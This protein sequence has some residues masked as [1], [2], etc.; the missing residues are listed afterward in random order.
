MMDIPNMKT[1]VKPV[2]VILWGMDDLLNWSVCSI[3]SAA[4]DWEVINLVGGQDIDDLIL[5]VK[6]S[7]PDAIVIHQRDSSRGTYLST[8]ILSNFQSMTVIIVNS[9]G[10]S[11][12][13]YSKKQICIQKVSDLISAIEEL[14]CSKKEKPHENVQTF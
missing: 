7:N 12:E 11:M 3:L 13:V 1:D 8:Q 10:N 5:E 6:R 4:Q 2:K 9:D 14:H